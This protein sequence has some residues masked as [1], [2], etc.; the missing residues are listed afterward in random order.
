MSFQRA[1]ETTA[2][3]ANLSVFF[4]ARSSF[5]S[6]L[7]FFF[8]FAR[9]AAFDLDICAWGERTELNQ[10]AAAGVSLK[11]RSYTWS[12]FRKSLIILGGGGGGCAF[13]HQLLVDCTMVA[14]QWNS[15]PVP[16][17]LQPGTMNPGNRTLKFGIVTALQAL[18]V[19]ISV[20]DSL[21][22]RSAEGKRWWRGEDANFCFLFSCYIKDPCPK[23]NILEYIVCVLAA[24]VLC[25]CRFLFCS[26]F[27]HTYSS[28]MSPL[29]LFWVHR[30]L[31]KI[32]CVRQTIRSGTHVY[33]SCV[34]AL[35]K[36]T[37]FSRPLH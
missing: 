1:T 21:L 10:S 26:P 22:S 17:T 3:C 32:V 23:V 11:R 12:Y 19:L 16:S 7:T 6:R 18:S 2:A 35:S 4:I 31:W 34:N 9:D 13:A 33:I 27:C 24:S 14:L 30:V 29:W 5:S 25:M 28:F 37:R 8:F 20:C 36:F 15:W